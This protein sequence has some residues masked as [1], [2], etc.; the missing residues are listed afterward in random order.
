MEMLKRAITDEELQIFKRSE[1]RAAEEKYLEA[2]KY[3]PNPPREK[4]SKYAPHTGDKQRAKALK[5]L[6]AELAKVSS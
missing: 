5:R 1:E 3:G 2:R 6:E 4:H